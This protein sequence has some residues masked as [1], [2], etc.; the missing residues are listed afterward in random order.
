M[1]TSR[2]RSFLC[3]VPLL[4]LAW[5][6]PALA[7][8]PVAEA[9]GPYTIQEG[10]AAVLSAAGSTDADG[11]ISQYEW[12]CDNDGSFDGGG[13]AFVGCVFGDDG[14]FVVT[15]RV[16]DDGGEQD[17]DTANVVVSNVAP[18]IVS[19]LVPT[20][21]EGLALTFS[22]AA[23]DPGAAQDPLIYSWDFGDGLSGTGASASHIYADEGSYPVTLT[24]SDGDGGSATVTAVAEVANVAP[25][26][27]AVIGATAGDEGQELSWSVSVSDAG[28]ADTVSLSWDFGDGVVGLGSTNQNHTYADD[29]PYTL[30]I[31]ATDDDGG[32]AVSTLGVVIGDVAPI[33]TSLVVPGAV[34]GDPVMLSATAT[35][36]GDDTLTYTWDLGDGSPVQMGP[37]VVWIYGEDGSYTV[38]LTVAAED[39][40]PVS[41]STLCV[42]TNVAPEITSLVADSSGLEG[43]VRN[44]SVTVVDPGPADQAE[45]AITWDFADGTPT[46]S[47]ASVTHAFLDEGNFNV[48]VTVDDGDGGVDTGSS[49]IS[50]QNVAPQFTSV[51]PASAVEGSVYSYLP[52]VDE[53]GGDTLVWTLSPSAPPAMVQDG[54]TGELTWTP[55]FADHQVGSYAVTITVDDG[56]GGSD[57]QNWTITVTADDSDGDGIADGWEVDNGLDPT[58][59]SDAGADPDGDGLTSLQ[60]YGLGQNPFSYDGPSTPIPASPVQ[61]ATT[62]TATPDLV[63]LAATDPQGEALLYDF[64]I[65]VDEALTTLVTSTSGEPEGAASQV[66]WK[67]DASLAENTSY[68]WRVRAADAAVAGIWSSAERFFINVSN[69]APPAPVLVFPVAETTDV[70]T[71]TLEWV[72]I[73]EPD[74]DEV[75]YSVRVTPV[76][77]DAS[78]QLADAPVVAV[79]DVADSGDLNSTLA[80]ADALTEDSW[81]EWVVAATD[82]DGLTGA[83]SEAARFFVSSENAAPSAVVFLDPV[84]GTSL[85]TVSPVLTVSESIDPEGGALSYLFELDAVESFDSEAYESGV[86]DSQQD[87]PVSWDLDADSV[88]LVENSSVYARVRATDAEGLSSPPTTITLYVRGDNDPPPVPE[89][90]Q[91]GEGLEIEDE[92][93][94]LVAADVVDPEG[95]VVF[96][97]FLVARDEQ[98][99]L[100]VA[101]GEELSVLV[102]T[103]PAEQE[104]ATSWQVDDN[105]SG[106]VFWSARAV[107]E[108]GAASDWA[109]PVR[110]VVAVSEPVV[111]PPPQDEGSACSS[112]GTQPIAPAVLALFAGLVLGLARRREP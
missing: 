110:F 14:T 11:A 93:P 80:L 79:G 108:F 68:W 46:A 67:S 103:G 44:F 32:S 87:G 31:T 19:H 54:S 57:V 33:I 62:P 49:S 83:W 59:P 95:D 22:A 53:P 84:D 71:P 56:D 41:Q 98:M 76:I 82:A 52:V 64:E 69:E 51:P 25:V 18:T 105:L 60:E 55:G 8:A 104:G 47:G 3:A 101:G 107:D 92:V 66:S 73:S 40:N 90:L 23:T 42:I 20:G 75:S 9:N 96:Y 89:L 6:S 58:D 26:I 102:G 37:T 30:T 99:L 27:V 34:E 1:M 78:G 94:V 97:D 39:G 13:L 38:T 77:G 36:P 63:A 85:D 106:V 109:T 48:T 15:L 65:Y 61:G 43:E 86:I 16:T 24:V 81:Y 74:G 21:D 5:A 91:P 4:C 112:A 17:T 35:D 72:N 28:S 12:D 10:A 111:V 2:S 45:I 7:D 100:E 70:L 29:G 88:R 50:I